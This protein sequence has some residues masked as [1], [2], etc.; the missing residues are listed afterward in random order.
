MPAYFLSVFGVVALF[1]NDNFRT[2]P[3]IAYQRISSYR[4]EGR[5]GDPALILFNMLLYVIYP[6]RNYRADM[7]KLV[8][9]WLY[10]HLPMRFTL[11]VE[12]LPGEQVAILG[13]SGARALRC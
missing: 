7:L 5:R 10:H 2:L 13:P 11:A 6:H 4:S 9:H 12:H 8:N 1:G 3:F